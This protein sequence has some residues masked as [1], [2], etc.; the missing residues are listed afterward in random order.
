M[1]LVLGSL[2]LLHYLHLV[3]GHSASPEPC[4]VL[5]GETSIVGFLWQ[6]NRMEDDQ[7][8]LLVALASE[9]PLVHVYSFF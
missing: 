8:M 7:M 3:I 1:P 9:Y 2:D 6:V 5:G 4:T